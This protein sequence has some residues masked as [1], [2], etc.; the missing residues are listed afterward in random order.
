MRFQILR[1]LTPGRAPTVTALAIVVAVFGVLALLAPLGHA[2]EPVTRAGALLAL[3]GALEILHGIRRADTASLRRAV[4]SGLI[5]FLMGVLVFSA[6]YLAGGALVLLLSITF[7]IDAASSI[8]AARRAQGRERRFSLLS[9][10]GDL[11]AA[12]GL[13]VLTQVSPTWLVA[14]AAALRLFG[15]AWNITAT[16]AHTADDAARTVVDDLGLADHPEASGLR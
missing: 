5:S 14:V 1:D 12:A 9:A 3:G 6:P 7:A 16:P 4:T 15:I 2:E 8:V 13:I 10:A 11:T